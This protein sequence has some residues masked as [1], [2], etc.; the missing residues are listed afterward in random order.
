MVEPSVAACGSGC[1]QESME[2]KRYSLSLPG[3]MIHVWI[4]PIGPSSDSKVDRFREYLSVDEQDRAERFATDRLR[5]SFIQARG[6]LR[7]LLGRYL[8]IKPKEVPLSYGPNG[9]SYV[10]LNTALRFS[11]SHSHNLALFAFTNGCELGVDIEEVRPLNDMLSIANQFFCPEEASQ[12]ASLPDNLRERAFYLCWTRKEAYVKAIGEGLSTPLNMFRVTLQPGEPV[13]F[14]HINSDST[15]A[16][17]WNLHNFLLPESY[18][19]ALAYRDR[20][21]PVNVFSVLSS[22]HVHE[23]A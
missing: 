2:T 20:V 1:G 14:L 5:C 21:R 19:G 11:T 7:T 8:G 13:R 23:S 12:L 4:T 3:R 9:K 22:A 10:Q 18:A 15:A 16:G 17:M 6:T